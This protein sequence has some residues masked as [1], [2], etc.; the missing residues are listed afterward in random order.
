MKESLKLSV[1]EIPSDKEPATNCF[2]ETRT[3]LEELIQAAMV[4]Y[5]LIGYSSSW[6]IMVWSSLVRVVSKHLLSVLRPH[7]ITKS[8]L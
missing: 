4:E 5:G 6:Y 3:K 1:L 2:V 7:G 8:G